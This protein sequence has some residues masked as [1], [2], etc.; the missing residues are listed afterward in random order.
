[1]NVKKEE[2]KNNSQR[3]LRGECALGSWDVDGDALSE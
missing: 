3:Q 1:M 2:V